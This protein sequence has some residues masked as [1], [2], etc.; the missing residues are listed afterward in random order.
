MTA[1][2][3][4]ITIR[5]WLKAST[6]YLK[7]EIYGYKGE[8]RINKREMISMFPGQGPVSSRQ[9]QYASR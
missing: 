8:N 9:Y 6:D 1:R 2:S 5:I 4:R 3:F 7:C